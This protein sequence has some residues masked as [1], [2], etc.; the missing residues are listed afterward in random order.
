MHKRIRHALLNIQNP[1]V[2]ESAYDIAWIARITDDGKTPQFKQSLY[3]ILE[4]QKEDGSWGAEMEYYHDRIMCTLSCILALD[5]YNFDRRY[6]NQ[7]ER[8][9]EYVCEN[10][11]NLSK[12]HSKTVGFE[13]LFPK[14]MD[15]AWTNGRCLSALYSPVAK[16]LDLRKEKLGRLEKYV[17][18]RPTTLLHSLECF[19]DTFDF[20]SVMKFQARNGSFL[21]SPSATAYVYMNTQDARCLEYLENVVEVFNGAVPVNYPLDIFRAN[22]ILDDIYT[23]GLQDEFRDKVAHL[24]NYIIQHWTEKG[25]SWSKDFNLPDLDNTAVGYRN[26]IHLGHYA[27]EQVFFNFFDGEKFFCFEGELDSGPSH[28]A[29]LLITLNMMPKTRF[30]DKARKICFEKLMETKNEDWSWS[31]KWHVSN[32]YVTSRVYRAMSKHPDIQRNIQKGVSAIQQL[33]NLT[34][35]EEYYVSVMYGHDTFTGKHMF[36]K[37]QKKKMWID[38]VLYEVEL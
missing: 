29:N 6:E 30:V 7:L 35:E 20:G 31:D 15:D 1:G 18:M 3:W 24:S 14:L 8:A 33:L 13:V 19:D 9:E 36:K 4:N 21:N 34:E 25:H 22:W 26:L 11:Q 5:Q 2:S 32:L 38:K 12:D 10:I 37:Q 27:S 17:G 23:F 28:I 16:Y